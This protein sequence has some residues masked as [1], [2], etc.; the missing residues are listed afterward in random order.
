[1]TEAT[2]NTPPGAG[3]EISLPAGDAAPPPAAKPDRVTAVS[4]LALGSLLM[5]LDVLDDWVDANVP[6]QTQALEQR[7]REQKARQPDVL[8]SQS[9]WEA[10][11]GRPEAD[12]SRLALLGIAATLNNRAVGATR[13]AMRTGGRAVGVARWPL[14]HIFL[15]RPLHSGKNRAAEAANQQIDRWVEVGREL[16]SGSRAVA[17][18]SLG[19]AAQDTVEIVTVEPHVQALIQEIVAAQGTG[20][21]QEII[22]EVREH[23]VSLDMGIDRAWATLRGRPQP[24][25]A[26]PD[27]AVAIPGKKPDAK[28]MAGRPYLGG[29]Y[30]GFVSRVLAFAIDVFALIIALIVTFVFVWGVVSIFNLD[31]LFQTLLGTH[32]F[33]LLRMVGSGVVGTLVACIYWIFGWMFIGGTAGKIVMGLRVVGPGGAR[34]GFWRSL[35]RVIGYFISAIFLG[36]GFLW[37]IVN[38]Q[39][40]IGPT[41]WPARRSSMPGTPAPMRR[42]WRIRVAD[43]ACGCGASGRGSSFSSSPWIGGSIMLPN[44]SQR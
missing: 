40:H 14:D 2:I 12:R 41:N 33:G 18:V 13:F 31:Q 42:L 1:M 26:T 39:H 16:D 15:F 30:A 27:F 36:L 34:L 20:I 17:E 37:V 19:H 11:Y 35:R 23:A 25:I 43:P 21:T 4:N 32:G 24:N 28:E 6:T 7:A 22:K 29:G 5:A 44:L 9:E 3:S 38:K 8:L 10:T